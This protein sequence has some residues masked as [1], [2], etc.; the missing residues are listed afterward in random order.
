VAVHG[1]FGAIG[2]RGFLVRDTKEVVFENARMDVAIGK[3]LVPDHAL[4]KMERNPDERLQ[5]W[6][7]E[8][9][10]SMRNTTP[11]SS[12]GFRTEHVVRGDD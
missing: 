2:T 11:R 7:A 12:S 10:L 9:V 3:L 6:F 8:S 5:R 4:V 1:R